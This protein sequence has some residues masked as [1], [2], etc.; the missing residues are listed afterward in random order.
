MYKLSPHDD[1]PLRQ[2]EI[3]SGLKRARLAIESVGND[4]EPV[5]DYEVHEYA[6]LMTQDC[7]LD[8]DHKARR[9]QVKL[10][11]IVPDI[12]LCQALPADEMRG[13]QG[14]NS[15]IWRRITRHAHERYQVLPEITP[16]KD[17]LGS[18]AP[19][20]GLDFKRIFTI[21][22]DEIYRRIALD[23]VRRRCFLKSPYREHL[24]HRFTH[25]HGRVA[26]P[27]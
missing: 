1:S 20:L 23:Q 25:F 26:L 6:I 19:R 5:V 8:L 18:G 2:C 12:L 13:E 10:D 21:P 14:I 11:K 4:E 9:D 27:E 3:V 16:D 24:I 22:A 17:L 15:D 7:D